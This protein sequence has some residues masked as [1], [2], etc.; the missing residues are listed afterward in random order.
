[1]ILDLASHITLSSLEKMKVFRNR[2]ESVEYHFFTNFTQF[3]EEVRIHSAAAIYF[4]K[5][6]CL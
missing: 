3:E 1:M 5:F 2:F 6:T 4:R